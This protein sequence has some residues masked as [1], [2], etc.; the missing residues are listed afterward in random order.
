MSVSE[1]NISKSLVFTGRQLCSSQLSDFPFRKGK[2]SSTQSDVNMFPKKFKCAVQELTEERRLLKR[3]SFWRISLFGATFT[4]QYIWPTSAYL[5]YFVWSHWK[6]KFV[7]FSISLVKNKHTD[8]YFSLLIIRIKYSH[9]MFE[10]KKIFFSKTTRKQ[11]ELI[12]FRLAKAAFISCSIRFRPSFSQ[13]QSL[14]ILKSW[15]K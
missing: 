12:H 6:V 3:K 10:R 14:G 2:C 4:K 7:Y 9:D 11:I 8:F 13:N 15:S 5:S 1:P